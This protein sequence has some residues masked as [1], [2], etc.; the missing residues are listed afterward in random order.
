M[1]FIITG[2]VNIGKST[3]TKA[4]L[5]KCQATLRAGVNKGLIFLDEVGP[6][7]LNHAGFHPP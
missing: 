7:E 6:L 3:V 2:E 1:N 4:V 5:H